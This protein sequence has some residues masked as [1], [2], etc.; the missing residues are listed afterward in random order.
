M[1]AERWRGLSLGLA[2][3][4]MLL[5][6]APRTVLAAA[7]ARPRTGE[8]AQQGTGVEVEVFGDVIVGR[9]VDVEIRAANPVPDASQGSITVSIYGNPSIQIAGAS[10][11]GAKI[12]Q[13]GE[14]M[15]NFGSGRASPISVPAVELFVSSWPA[16]ARHSLRLRLT[17]HGPY[18][19]QARASLRRAN[20][21]FVHLPG[22]G[23]VDQQ[24]APTRMIDLE[25]RQQPPPTNTPQPP[26]TNT[27]VPA[28]KPEQGAPAAKPSLQTIPKPGLPPVEKPAQPPADKPAQPPADKPAQAPVQSPAAPPASAESPTTAAPNAPPLGPA[29]AAT[30]T[31]AATPAGGGGPSMPLLLAGFGIMGLG[32]A[33]ALVALVMVL[34]RRSS[35]APAP[36]AGQ[37]GPVTLTPRANPWG[38]SPVGQPAR[39]P[40]GGFEMPPGAV[41]PWERVA[42][43]PAPPSWPQPSFEQGPAGPPDPQQAAPPPWGT[44][45]PPTSPYGTPAPSYGTSAPSYGTSAPSYG[46]SA[47]SYGTPAPPT[48]GSGPQPSA[49]GSTPAS[50]RY[51]DRTLTGRGGMGSVFRAY[52]SRLHRWVALKVMHADLGLQQGFMD[53]FVREAQM[54]AMLEHPN[55]VTVYDIEPVGDSIQMV[56]QWIDGEDLQKILERDGALPL[57]RAAH[58]LDQVAA[59]LD[60]AHQRERPILHRDIK[61]SNIMVGPH[62]RAILTD[63]GIARLIGDASLT[64]TGQ[65]VGT[66]AYM[67]PEVVRGEVAD[68]RADIYA[69]GVLLFQLVTGRVPFKA[70][71]PLAVL[72]AQIHTTPPAARSVM[73]SLSGGVEG[74][75]TRALAKDRDQRFQ[76]AG[77]LARAFRASIGQA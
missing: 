9:P 1:T 64:Q 3:L 13:P 32:V 76:T 48:Q 55:I 47:P 22:A 4:V 49:P 20:G 69:L 16:G 17:A 33:T 12:Y 27:A 70:E 28:T 42:G 44:P 36:L 25:P 39:P 54:A 67:A 24:G 59:A 8:T 74:V 45:L 50:E 41:P 58:L 26:P 73:P 56:M 6:L 11:Q 61:P 31:V 18:T 5:A 30:P 46:T 2:A 52:D 35:P 75:L 21:S 37:Y 57:P 40:S 71:T 43:T 7:T 53:R 77:A 19:L 63:F 29:Q 68:S 34:R 51:V 72:H 38:G 14:N 10:A 65:M 62:D 15:F 60:H 66:P 23:Q